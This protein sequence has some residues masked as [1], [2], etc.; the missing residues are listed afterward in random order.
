MRV[1]FYIADV[2]NTRVKVARCTPEAIGDVRSW[3]HD[4]VD[5]PARMRADWSPSAGDSWTI[6]GS[7]SDRLGAFR[8]WLEGHSQAVRTIASA[9]DLPVR[10]AVRHPETVGL[11][12]LL[13]AVAVAGYLEG[14]GRAIVVDAG[15][16]VT[17]DLVGIEGG[18]SAF[19]GGIILP[20]PRLMGRALND[21][22]AGLPRI[23]TFPD[24]AVLE[25]PG[26][27][28]ESAIRSG[29]WC[30]VVGGIERAIAAYRRGSAGEARIW[31]TGG[32]APPIGSMLGLDAGPGS[33]TLTLEGIR[34]CARVVE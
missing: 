6:S 32:Y 9:N 12:R 33:T 10:I 15:T 34:R 22:T 27:D 14:S 11:D 20:G 4:D 28:T 24:D 30:A 25:L 2:G 5:A 29:I 31:L 21:Y 23:E 26:L 16:A 18:V 3:Y 7:S 17:V 19:L 8:D 13:N 1:P